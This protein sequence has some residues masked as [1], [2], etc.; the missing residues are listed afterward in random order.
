M[1]VNISKNNSSLQLAEQL[2]LCVRSLRQWQEL[3][4]SYRRKTTSTGRFLEQITFLDNQTTALL[5]SEFI[6]PTILE[7]G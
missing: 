1:S 6:D 2:K 4:K 3:A 5:D 7:N